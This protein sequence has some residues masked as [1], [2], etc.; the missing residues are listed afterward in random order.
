M[1]YEDDNET[2]D[3]E[4]GIC[5]TTKIELKWNGEQEIRI[6]PALG[7]T[8]L[9]PEKRSY[10]LELYGC[11]KSDVTC[12]CNGEALVTE[13][14]YDE[15]LHCLRA[16]LP[17]LAVS[18]DIRLRF[19]QPVELARNDVAGRIYAFLDQAEIR[20]DDKTMIDGL[21]RSGKSPLVIISRLQ[22]SGLEEDLVKCICEMI[23][24]QG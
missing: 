14:S 9:I 18:A 1:L 19:D 13:Y 22:A 7:H 3:Y 24:A 17:A 12:T 2:C 21:V 23:T 20:F 15:T 6:H 5:A 4:K 16:A 10:T 8:E 11:T